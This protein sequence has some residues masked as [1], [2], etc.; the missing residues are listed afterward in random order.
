MRCSLN[1]D[2]DRLGRVDFSSKNGIVG[3]ARVVHK[4]SKAVVCDTVKPDIALQDL[5]LLVPLRITANW[6][7]IQFHIS[8]TCT[9]YPL[10]Y[11]RPGLRKRRF[12]EP[13]LTS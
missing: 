12:I 5:A 10:P 3:S 13:L 7:F 11:V 9:Q 8:N 2:G 1:A 6:W 4:H